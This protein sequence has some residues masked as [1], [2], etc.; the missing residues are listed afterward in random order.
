MS[1]VT[2]LGHLWH[3]RTE[4][5]VLYRMNGANAA[6]L[7]GVAGACGGTP[8]PPRCAPQNTSMYK[9]VA[10]APLFRFPTYR[11]EAVLNEA[12]PWSKRI[13]LCQW[14]FCN[15]MLTV[16]DFPTYIKLINYIH[17]KVV[18]VRTDTS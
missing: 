18:S 10:I 1:E 3:R 14:L 2:N 4:C 17:I 7:G 13:L 12:S 9:P 6:F 8:P 11:P 15:I 16:F 5:H